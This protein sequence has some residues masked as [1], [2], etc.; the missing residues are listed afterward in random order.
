MLQKFFQDPNG[1]DSSGRLFA[2]YLVVMGVLGFPAGVV[3]TGSAE[4]AAKFTDR[5]FFYAA[6]FYGSTKGYDSFNALKGKLASF[7]P[8]ATTASTETTAASG[9]PVSEK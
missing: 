8:Q 7:L 3:L 5:C 2:A 6:V 4:F 1:V 9:E